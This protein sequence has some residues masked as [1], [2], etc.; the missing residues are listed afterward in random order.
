MNEQPDD[1]YLWD[2]SGPSDEDV[3]RLERLLAPLAHHGRPPLRLVGP[4]RPRRLRLAVAAVVLA[5]VGVALFALARRNPVESPRAGAPSLR[6]GSATLAESA[7]IDASEG[8]VQLTLGERMG[9][10]TLEAGGRLQ[11]RRLDAEVARLYLDRGRITASIGADVRPRF[12]QVDTPG[13]RCVDLGC[14]YT[15][16]VDREGGAFVH[17]LTG[18]VAF[19]SDAG[20]VFVPANAT[21]R[22]APG[23]LA[24]T[25]RF[26]D[27]PPDL[28][29]A[30]DAY[31]AARSASADARRPLARA[32]CDHTQRIADTLGL[33]HLLA[34]PDP[35]IAD[36]AQTAL[37]RLAGGDL[38]VVPTTREGW[39]AELEWFWW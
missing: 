31:D 8:D 25:P 6:T 35:A 18:R 4:A 37:V 21:C 26:L 7:W 14:R 39:R 2:R 15:L 23:G 5:A 32:L 30:L 29:E 13:V 16:E 33:W 22:A 28:V 9:R 36:L 3:E 24:G 12:F 17:V 11:V 27:T 34:D 19:E 20:E 1:R 38:D 10:I